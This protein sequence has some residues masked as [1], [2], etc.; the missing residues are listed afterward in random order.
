MLAS[1]NKVKVYL[2]NEVCRI[3]NLYWQTISSPNHKASK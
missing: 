3:K 1:G 2:N